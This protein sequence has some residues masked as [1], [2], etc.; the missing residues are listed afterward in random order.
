MAK[1]EINKNIFI[2]DEETNVPIYRMNVNFINTK[3]NTQVIVD[4]TNIVCWWCTLNFDTIPCFLPEKIIDD[5]YYVF[6]N[7]CSVNCAA[8][9][10]VDMNDFKV[11]ERYG[12]LKRMYQE[13]KGVMEINIAPRRECLNKFGGPITEEEYRENLISNHKEYRFVHPPMKSIIPF[14][15][16]LYTDSGLIAIKKSIYKTASDT[17]NLVLKR[18]K[19][20]PG[21]KQNIVTTFQELGTNKSMKL[22]L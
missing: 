5:T 18:N 4:K 15:E 2:K 11:W 12:L 3:D 19:P 7:F 22:T 9:Y 10:N 6:G 21:S 13:I 16:E 1:K 20:L 14:I 17:E 8:A